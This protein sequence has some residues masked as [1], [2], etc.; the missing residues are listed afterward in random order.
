MAGQDCTKGFI[1]NYTVQLSS[2][3]AIRLAAIL[4]VG[5]IFISMLCETSRLENRCL[6]TGAARPPVALLKC[7]A[8][9]V[10]F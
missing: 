10:W 6:W 3:S 1:L 5:M 4:V 7:G 9:V 2:M 8:R